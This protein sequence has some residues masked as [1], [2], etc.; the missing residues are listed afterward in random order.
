MSISKDELKKEI[1]ETVKETIKEL[2]KNGELYEIIEEI[3]LKK[4][5]DEGLKSKP[6]SSDEVIKIL[7]NED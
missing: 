1:K 5:I 6:V 7:T 3:A 2:I 4:A